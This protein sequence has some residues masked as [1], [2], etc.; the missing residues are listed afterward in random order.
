LR[1]F[2]SAL[3]NNQDC[4]L[5]YCEDNGIRIPFGL[6]SYYYIQKNKKGKH[7]WE[8]IKGLCDQIMV[9]SGAHSF[10]KGTVVNWDEY[11]KN[12]ADFIKQ[13]DSD[14]IIGFFEMDVDVVLG[15]PKV[16]ELRQQLLKSSSKIIPVWH[17]NRGIDE[18]KRE[19][20]ESSSK[21]IS[22]TGFH[23]ED[24]LDEQYPLFLKYAWAQG[25]KVHCLGMTRNT[26]LD[27]VP[28]D[29]VDSST[30][31]QQAIFGNRAI[32]KNGRIKSSPVTRMYK[33]TDLKIMNFIEWSKI[34]QFY[35]HK[36]QKVNHDLYNFKLAVRNFLRKLKLERGIYIEKIKKH[37]QN[38]YSNSI[39]CSNYFIN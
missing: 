32:F 16:L 12:Y 27:K 4:V 11:T 26:I 18:F 13:E 21:I 10:Q 3:E 34:V 2:L 22:I 24:I 30:W 19:C 39:V 25:K 15:Y 28:F 9:D 7:V 37:Y 35:N 6:V 8:R 31:I 1:I 23:N 17:K 36:W 20:R 29:Y 38:S 33:S 5:D 14:Q